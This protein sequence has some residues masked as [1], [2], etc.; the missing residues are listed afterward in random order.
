MAGRSPEV[1]AAASSVCISGMAETVAEGS[2]TYS[3]CLPFATVRP[4]IVAVSSVRGLFVMT[5]VSGVEES[6]ARHL[7]GPT[8]PRRAE[9]G[10]SILRVFH[11]PPSPCYSLVNGEFVAFNEQGH[12]V[13]HYR[14]VANNVCFLLRRVVRAANLLV[15]DAIPRDANT[16]FSWANHNQQSSC[17]MARKE[18]LWP[19]ALDGTD[20]EIDTTRLASAR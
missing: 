15:C 17:V 14:E 8:R 11:P 3:V 20:A 1:T 13:A 7:R 16:S 19:L 5:I 12:R 4:L 6:I 2:V 10:P 18:I 9:I